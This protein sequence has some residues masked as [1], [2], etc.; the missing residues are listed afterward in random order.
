MQIWAT[1]VSHE[2]G[3]T[4]QDGV[5]LAVIR[6]QVV[7]QNR[8]RFRRVPRRLENRQ[9]N[10]AEFKRGTVFHRRE[11]VFSLGRGSEVDL[12]TRSVSEL[13]MAGEEV[14][15]EVGQEYVTDLDSKPVRVSHVLVHVP[16]WID[17]RRYEAFLIGNQI[18]GMREAA[19]VV[20]FEVHP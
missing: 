17:D 2:K 20:L 18:R 9:A 14:C 19:E 7:H 1:D 16:L 12:S 15:V 11:R 8:D 3:V 6:L 10:S 4:S 5:G 13:E